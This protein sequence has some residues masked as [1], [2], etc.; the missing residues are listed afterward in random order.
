MDQMDRMDIMDA[1]GAAVE[2][3]V[4]R[5]FDVT[6]TPNAEGPITGTLRLRLEP[7][8]VERTVVLRGSATSVQ[9]STPGLDFGT[10]SSGTTTTGTLRYTN[11][12]TS[13]LRIDQLDQS[14]MNGSP[15]TVLSTTPALPARCLSISKC[16]TS[17]T[18]CK[19]R[20]RYG[21]RFPRRAR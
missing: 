17:G 19:P 15:F 16:A 3:G 5:T 12:G 13:L 18:G 4:A 10:V 2:D 6:F 21:L 11:I 14:A 7:C 20:V 9:L 1:D 8:G